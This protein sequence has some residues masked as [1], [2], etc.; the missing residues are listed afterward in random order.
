MEL[1]LFFKSI[2]AKYQLH[3][4]AALFLISYIL[5]KTDKRQ[6][7]LHQQGANDT[8]ENRKDIDKLGRKVETNTKDIGKIRIFLAEKYP[9]HEA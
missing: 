8:K 4:T 7:L 9:K 6:A 2:A 5:I 1:L 3:N